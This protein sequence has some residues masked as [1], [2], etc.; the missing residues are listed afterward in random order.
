MLGRLLF[1]HHNLGGYVKTKITIALILNAFIVIPT[2]AS[3]I[4]RWTDPNTG[5]VVTTPSLPPYPIKEKR[6]AGQLPSGDLI[7]VIFDFN[8][9][10]LKAI[11]E[12]RK[13][14]E[15]EEKRIFEEKQKQKAAQEEQQKRIAAQEAKEAAVREVE[16]QR[17]AKE[18]AAK[19]AEYWKLVAKNNEGIYKTT[20]TELF[21]DYEEN[22]VNTDEKIKG[23]IV[24]ISGSVQSIDKDFT[25]SI[26]I[27]IK[28]SNQFMPAHLRVDDSQKQNAM[29]LNRGDEVTLRCQKVSRIM[30]SPSGRDC[31]F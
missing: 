31:K 5:K 24:E 12:K 27:K 26:I 19:E 8:T 16:Y 1:L 29:T 18:K 23:K 13:A 22:E 25:D 15:A 7:E 4:Y 21:S 2:I 14:Q 11:I 9:P 6:V 10:E 20:A 17:R 28:T 30:G 3:D